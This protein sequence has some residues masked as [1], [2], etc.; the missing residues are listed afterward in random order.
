ML[1]RSEVG[2]A[3]FVQRKFDPKEAKIMLLTVEELELPTRLSNALYKA[4]FKTVYDLLSTSRSTIAKVKNLGA[5]SI[6]V[7]EKALTAH[8][9]KLED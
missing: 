8:G 9:I 4:G 5:K 6:D 2:K 3:D 7:V 1:F